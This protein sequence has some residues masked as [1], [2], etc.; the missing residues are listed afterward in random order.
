MC[1]KCNRDINCMLDRLTDEF[2]L[3]KD[4]KSIEIVDW[5][6]Y[7]FEHTFNKKEFWELISELQ[8]LHNK[9]K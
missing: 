4:K 9:I 6:D 8:E 1:N 3:S 7:Y 2:S 5:I